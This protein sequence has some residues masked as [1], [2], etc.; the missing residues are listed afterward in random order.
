MGGDAGEDISDADGEIDVVLEDKRAGEIFI[1][2]LGPDVG[3]G[4]PAAK[5][6]GSGGFWWWF[7][8]VV[9]KGFIGDGTSVNLDLI[10]M[11]DLI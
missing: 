1:D 3:V 11:L 8:D 7:V 5:F 4:A 10:M 6:G 9:G 2:D